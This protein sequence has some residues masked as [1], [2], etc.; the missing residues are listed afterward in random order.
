MANSAR[1]PETTHACRAGLAG[2]LRLGLLLGDLGHHEAA[3]ELLRGGVAHFAY[4]DP[5]LHPLPGERMVRVDEHRVAA[6]AHHAKQHR[7]AVGLERRIRVAYPYR[8]VL[9]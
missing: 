9:G 4:G 3:E 6:E 7:L 8:L 1:Q 2:E 5:D